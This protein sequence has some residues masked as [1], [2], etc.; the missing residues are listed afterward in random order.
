MSS[1]LSF[2]NGNCLII[3]ILLAS[4]R[5]LLVKSAGDTNSSSV[6]GAAATND[7]SIRSRLM[8]RQLKLILLER[9]MVEKKL[10][11]TP[12]YMERTFFYSDSASFQ[13]IIGLYADKKLSIGANGV[14]PFL[15]NLT[16]YTDCVEQPSECGSS[17]SYRGWSLTEDYVNFIY[18]DS[19]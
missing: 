16:N 15:P 5:P 19:K 3:I 14:A 9:N 7:R 11:I 6:P 4:T 12:K 1:S 10:P 8:E 13:V 2:C 17:S 18:T